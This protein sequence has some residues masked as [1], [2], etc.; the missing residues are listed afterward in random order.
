MKTPMEELLDEITGAMNVC[1]NEE[2]KWTY[3]TIASVIKM[4]YL[5][6][7]KIMNITHDNDEVLPKKVSHMRSITAI[8]SGDFIIIRD[9]THKEDIAIEFSGDDFENHAAVHLNKRGIVINCFSEIN[10]TEII[11]LTNNFDIRI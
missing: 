11:F 4:K 7:E 10:D 5:Q 6:K 8:K 2:R 9:N 1:D 3:Q